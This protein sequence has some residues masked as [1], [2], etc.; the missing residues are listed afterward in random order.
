MYA[1]GVASAAAKRAEISQSAGAASSG[2]N[3]QAKKLLVAGVAGLVLLVAAV[4]ALRMI[5][6]SDGSAGGGGAAASLGEDAK[7]EELIS[8]DGGTEARQWLSERRGRILS[9][10]TDGQ[11]ARQVDRWYEMGATKVLAFGGQMSMNVALELPKDPEKRAALFDWVNK[12]HLESDSTWVPDKDVGQ[13]YLL[14][15]LRI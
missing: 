6:S 3:A 2:D 15:R 1:G 14:V 7:V 13:K 8:D 5:G 9:G 4:I 10:M 12:W 11:A